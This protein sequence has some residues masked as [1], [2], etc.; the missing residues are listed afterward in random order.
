MVGTRSQTAAA[1]AP[2]PAPR[3]LPDNP[4]K[5]RRRVVRRRAQAAPGSR[6][7]GTVAGIVLLL[8][9]LGMRQAA[10]TALGYEIDA[11]KQR[12]ET[13]RAERAAL[14]GELAQLAAPARIE[15]Q[16]VQL[17]MET[18]GERRVARVVDLEPVTP[19]EDEGRAVVVALSKPAAAEPDRVT[20]EGRPGVLSQLSARLYA[21]LSG[22]QV[23]AE[24]L[25]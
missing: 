17:G 15:R 8:F 11:A 5:P 19:S 12:L 6:F 1:A 20:G 10:I 2:I 18:S 9:I 4:L 14:A 22:G 24:P 13:L 16:A 25:Y 21:W 3:A 7:L 23:Q